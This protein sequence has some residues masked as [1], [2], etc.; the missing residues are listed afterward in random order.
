MHRQVLLCLSVSDARV[1]VRSYDDGDDDGDD[2]D[3]D[4]DDCDG[5]DENDAGGGGAGA[6]GGGDDDD[7]DD[8][9]IEVDV[10]VG[11]DPSCARL[12]SHVCCL[13]AVAFHAEPTFMIPK[14]VKPEHK[15][16]NPHIRC[17]KYT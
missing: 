7:D 4:N 2:N 8:D 17:N 15:S 1:L 6:G 14:P 13:A 16:P 10:D 3:D 11:D 5:V 9:D 12:V